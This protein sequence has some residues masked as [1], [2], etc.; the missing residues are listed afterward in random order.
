MKNRESQAKIL[1][2]EDRELDRE[3][4]TTILQHAKY[5]V[6]QA[7]DGPQALALVRSEHPD[8]VISD[9]LLPGMDGFEL[10]RQMRSDPS[11]SSTNV[12]FYTAVFDEQEARELAEECG[13]SQVLFK[14]LD[15]EKILENVAESL[16]TRGAR[17]IS[18]P[19]ASFE[20]KHLK[21]LVNKLKGQVKALQQGKDQLQLKT[22]IMSA[23]NHFFHEALTCETEPKSGETCLAMAQD[24]IRKKS[25]LIGEPKQAGD[26][27]VL[28]VSNHPELEAGKIPG[29]KNPALPEGQAKIL[30]V[31]DRELDREML[32]TIL[33]HAQYRVQEAA[34]GPQ[35]L[36]L[37]RSEHP[38]LVISDLLLPGMDGYQLV[39]EL[40]SDPSI[41]GTGVIF[42][43]A[44]FDEQEARELAQECGVSRVLLKPMDPEK[45]LEN[46]AEVLK[47]RGVQEVQPLSA[48]FEYKH[49]QLLVDK[50][51]DQVKALQ[52]SEERLQM[53]TQILTGINRVFHE[54]LTTE[55]EEELA[56][57]SLEVAKGLTGSR[58]ALMGKVNQV[59][60][61]D[62]ALSD[63]EWGD[64][65]V[66][67]S[68]KK[69]VPDS[70]QHLRGFFEKVITEGRSLIANDLGGQP[71]R[72]AP[73]GCPPLTAFLGVPLKYAGKAIGLI[74]LGNLEGSYDPADQ[75]A[76]ETLS[77]AI[78]EALLRKRGEAALKQA[79]DELEW[80][81]EERTADLKTAVDQLEEEVRMRR[82]AEEEI[83]VINEELE[84]RVKDRT[85]ELEATN[86][87]LE[88]FSYSVAHD[89]KTPIRAIEGFSRM[90]MGEHAGKL[91]AEALRLLK[92]ICTNTKIMAQLI[93][94]LLGLSRLTRQPM[95][96]TDIHLADMARQVFERL[97]FQAT[98]RNLQLTVN[99]LPT[100]YGDHSLL[101]Q[102]MMNILGN[103]IKYTSSRETAL[104]EVGGRCDGNE[105]IYF[106][107]DNGIGFDERYLDK[108]FGPFQRL[109]GLEEYEGTGIGLA[110]VQR[111]IQKHGGRVWAEGKVGAGATFY[112]ALPKN[113]VGGG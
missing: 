67:G 4:L 78:V 9:L 102:A 51:V 80:R 10:V 18:P 38:D 25:G 66:S 3:M 76:V 101:Y 19:P 8:L 42:Y 7:A 35:A 48:S 90:L 27:G 41:S 92:V 97:K 36:A 32:A 44:V 85:A 21:L 106:V 109:H 13:V 60:K 110:I 55:T 6:Q 70:F 105:N 73:P 23:I 33:Q 16:K 75:E 46:V 1:V 59:R 40:R 31:E 54:A 29:R 64:C 49:Q 94:D 45:I 52:R 93:N 84:T 72:A 15:P 24:L 12:I 113:A 69:G 5:R 58:F 22:Q 88:S 34:D 79:R 53:K 71:D 107:K 14:P 74:G 87:E 82:E 89:L 20:Q 77:F 112:F 30:V 39:R 37:V 98:G 100:A 104:I 65:P 11:I 17:P 68:A 57:T 108:L 61:V 47:A 43:T 103:A 56:R 99:D 91:D 83:Q 86:Q 28:A 2:V 95:R 81:V 62:I 50:L 26:Q 63:P 111:I 96:K